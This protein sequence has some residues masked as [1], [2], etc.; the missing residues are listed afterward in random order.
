PGPHHR[1]PGVL[2][3]QPVDGS[4]IL[5]RFLSP[6]LAYKY[7]KIEPFGVF[8]ILALL[9]TNI[10]SLILSPPIVG[11]IYVINKLFHIV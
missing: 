8:I 3:V 7:S 9:A 5:M 2:P 10:L 1:E 6:S 4:R 11:S